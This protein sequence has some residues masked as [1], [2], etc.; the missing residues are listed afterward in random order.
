MACITTDRVIIDDA[1][2][3]AYYTTTNKYLDLN[4]LELYTDKLNEKFDAL[5]K[6]IEK[7]EKGN[8]ITHRN[9]KFTIVMGE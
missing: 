7:L 3:T 2:N 6:R 5:S 1:A 9:K 8:E 4:G